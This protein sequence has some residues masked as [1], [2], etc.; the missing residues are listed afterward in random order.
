[1]IMPAILPVTNLTDSTQEVSSERYSQAMFL[2]LPVFALLLKVFYRKIYYLAHLVFA[3]HL[4]SAMFMTFALM[5]V[6]E[7]GADRHLFG[8]II[9]S[10]VFLAMV[11]YAVVALKTAYCESW[12]KSILKFMGLFMLF[13]PIIGGAIELASRLSLS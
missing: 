6:L 9:Q 12:I 5:L 2:L 1:L 3:V 7:G 4:F 8:A 13:L 11:I 10:S